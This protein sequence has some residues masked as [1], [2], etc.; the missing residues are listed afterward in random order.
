MAKANRIKTE[1]VAHRVPQTHDECVEAIAAIGRLQRER[2]RIEATMND[3]LAAIR[4]AYEAEAKPLGDEIRRLTDGVQTF[5]EANRD[6]LTQGG[7]V[8]FARLASGEIKWRMRPPKVSLRGID[9]IIDAC[10]RLGLARFV[11]VKE[12]INKDAMLAEPEVAQSL[13]GVSISQGE[14]FV[15]MPFE[16]ELEEVA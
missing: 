2:Q 16:T 13:T 12:E 6:K 10:K 8:K 7:K 11:R 3:D 4:Q 14:D 9:N 5:C 15:V 1:A